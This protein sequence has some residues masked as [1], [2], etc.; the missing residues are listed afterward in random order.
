MSEAQNREEELFGAALDMATSERANFLTRA[1]GADGGLR[2]RVNHLLRAH[3]AAQDFMEAPASDSGMSG[4]CD[5]VAEEKPGDRI[6]R[7][8]LLQKIGEGGCGVVY[9]AEQ[10]E[11]V[12]RRVALKIIKLGMDTKAVIARFEAERQA[13]ARMDHANIA[14]VLDSGAT[15]SGRPFF[16]MDLVRGLKITDYCD[17]SNLSTEGRLELF[18]KVCHAI[19]HAHQ[20]GIIHRDIKPSNILVTLHD[21][22]PVPKVIDFGIAKATQGRLTDATLFTAFEQFMGTPAYVS[23]EQAE[24]SGL[25]IDT[26]SDIYSLGVLLYE[27]L[28]GRTP[29]DTKELV[30][31]GIDEMRRRIREQ[32]PPRPSIRVRTLTDSDQSTLA[33]RRGTDVP[34]LRLR[35]CGDLDWIV[36]RCLEKDRSR[37][38]E[39]ANGLAM[40]IQRHLRNEPVSARPPSTA[41]LLGKVIRRHRLAFG[42]GAA[43]TLCLA[44]GFAV[45]TSLYLAEREAVE[46]AREAEAIARDEKTRAEAAQAN[47]A[48]LRAEA[49]AGKQHALAAQREAARRAQL[50]GVM[51]GMLKDIGLLLALGGGNRPAQHELLEQATARKAELVDQPDVAAAVDEA[52]GGLYFN[53]GEFSRAEALFGEALQLRRRTHGE[54]APEVA[55]TLNHLGLLYSGRSNWAKAEEAHRQAL[56]LQ[57]RHFGAEDPQVARTLSTLGWVQAQQARL[58]E[59]ELNLRLALEQ[60]RK[61]KSRGNVAA[62][63]TRLGSI[64]TQAGRLP[65]AEQTLREAVTANS[66]VYGAN[67]LEAA[68]ALNHLAIAMV[69]TPARI[70]EAITVYRKAYDIRQL[71]TDSADSA[72]V[73][74]P[75]R[76]GQTAESAAAG[77][78]ARA[79]TIESMMTQPF[80]L[81]EVEAALRDAVLF[82]ETVYGKD[83]WQEAF[84]QALRVWVLVH[85][86]RF[87]EAEPIARHCLEVRTLLQPDDWSTHHVRHLLGAT[88]AGQNQY[89]AAK[90][91]LVEGYTAMKARVTSIPAFHLPRIGEAV[92]RIIA[93][94]T[95][96]NEPAEVGKWQAELAS[97]PE[98]WKTVVLPTNKPAPTEAPSRGPPPIR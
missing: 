23:P 88:L 79:L 69:S 53:L 50:A 84:Y 59:A 20:K 55:Q 68:N 43:L 38:Y 1:C 4:R 5:V 30:E 11:A 86:R 87:T 94:Y 16:V 3:E 22:M 10:E 93:Y 46:R 8:K 48:R 75:A 26:R 63:L 80:G 41:Y 34:K 31:A 85:E 47:E 65:E 70:P 37:R 89:G 33:K 17:Q 62:N 18:I 90:T 76:V 9:M 92:Q 91:P 71:I 82:A 97:L 49:E 51:T 98:E 42:A 77:A 36:M 29:F 58:G 83:S 14:R 64:L 73:T 39:T 25:D 24:M 7:Y 60:E 32:E 81:A 27:L 52:L 56:E 66:D 78:E 13:L 54:N 2:E 28:T 95:I 19:Q 44:A 12:R 6:G 35:L 61:F 67:S 45:S 57:R 21:G 96:V 40:D 72:A 74:E 15:A